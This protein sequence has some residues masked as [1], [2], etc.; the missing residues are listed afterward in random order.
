M[1]QNHIFQNQ[2]KNTLKSRILVQQPFNLGIN[3]RELAFKEPEGSFPAFFPI[4]SKTYPV[5]SITNHS[6]KSILILSSH[7]RLGLRKD[8]PPRFSH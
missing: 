4:L 3:W 7:L 5:S 2:I 1:R 8:L 6:L